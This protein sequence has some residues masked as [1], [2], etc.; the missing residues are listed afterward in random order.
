MIKY[1]IIFFVIIT[2]ID[3]F[4]QN[5]TPYPII[6]VHGL[7]GSDQ[8]FDET[9]EYL[10]NYCNLGNINVFDIV[11]NA[12]NDNDSSLLSKDVRY[13]DFIYSGTNI[14]VGR[15][16][17]K[18]DIADFTDGWAKSSIFAV[19]F[20]EERIRGAYGI[21]NDY[22]DYSNQAAIF[23][24]GFAL[25]KLIN[26]VL[27]YTNAKKVIL[28]G[29]S[30]G[31]L[32]IREYLQRTNQIGKH[33]NWVDPNLPDGHKV[34]RVITY[35]TPHLGSNTGFDPTKSGTPDQNTEAM[36]DMK[37][38]YDS[39]TNCTDSPATGI[40]L[41]GGNEY[42]IQS[43]DSN[44]TFFNADINCNGQE[45]DSIVGIC[46]QTYDNPD[47]PL[48]LDIKY[49]WITSIWFDWQGMIG[50]GAVAIDRQ[51]LYNNNNEPMPQGLADTLLSNYIHTS[52]GGDYY[53][54]IRGLDIPE[55]LD[56]AYC[57]NL[58]TTYIEWITLQSN[59]Q[60]L[61]EDAFY[62]NVNNN[63]EIGIILDNFGSGIGHI[64]VYNENKQNIFSDDFFFLPYTKNINSKGN[65]RL[66]FKI[67][68]LANSQTYKIPY[69]I[70]IF[71]HNVS[72]KSNNNRTNSFTY[73][74]N[75]FVFKNRQN[76][77][78]EIINL[79]G[80]LVFC[81]QF[82]F[83]TQ[84]VRLNLPAGLYI[85]KYTYNNNQEISKIIIK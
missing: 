77:S 47:M 75:E 42:C 39:F 68:G 17:Y 37:W 52:E 51:W 46:Y 32:A 78:L 43:N 36:R 59:L 34:A 22:F 85:A 27:N 3:L 82:L 21:L 73:F 10:K 48:P 14:N 29:H 26:E 61:D 57:L 66:Y 71:S 5:K 58:D 79:Y 24:Q 4:A 74:N 62:V 16:N 56:F 18:D 44:T 54:I 49:T 45:H 6:F 20:K 76:G 60:N 41:F 19:N 70:G 50:D 69:S 33:V 13:T 8:T 40:Y 38:V 30:M 84:N 64:D 23:K 25:G 83:G 55:D 28:V 80:Q 67:S 65:N 7:A 15:R 1:V 53:N 2:N 9:M 72:I 31:G 35:G 81:K 11:L 63:N 12:D